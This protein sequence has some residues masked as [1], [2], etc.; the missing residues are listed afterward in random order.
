M[1]RILEFDSDPGNLAGMRRFVREFL[2]DLPFEKNEADLMVLGLDEACANIIRY[3]Y[4]NACNQPISLVCEPLKRGVRFRVRDFGEQSDPQTFQPRPLDDPRPGGLG[5]HLIRRAF[6]Q[7]DY[8]LRRKG[9]ELV[10]T[11]RLSTNHRA[12]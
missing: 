11:K 2:A 5:I 4:N 12:E 10:L 6:D 8:T 7:V 9:T 3:A 1:K